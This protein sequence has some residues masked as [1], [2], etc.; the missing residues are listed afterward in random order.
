MCLLLLQNS[1]FGIL[2]KISSQGTPVTEIP[3]TNSLRIGGR[4]Y[5]DIAFV[6]NWSVLEKGFERKITFGSF[7]FSAMLNF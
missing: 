5:E 7:Y 3:D 4:S 1:T 2:C 6:C